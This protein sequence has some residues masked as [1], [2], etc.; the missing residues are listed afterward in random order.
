MKK[1]LVLFFLCCGFNF[2][3]SCTPPK[4]FLSDSRSL[5]SRVPSSADPFV[6][7][8]SPDDDPNVIF[9]FTYYPLYLFQSQGTGVPYSDVRISEFARFSVD[10]CVEKNDVLAGTRSIVYSASATPLPI[11]MCNDFVFSG[12]LEYL[13]S[14]VFDSCSFFENVG[15]DFYFSSFDYTFSNLCGSSTICES[16]G[17]YFNAKTKKCEQKVTQIL[18]I[19]GIHTNPTDAERNRKHLEQSYIDAVYRE[20]SRKN[21]AFIFDL[22]YNYHEGFFDD[23]GEV[24][25][26]KSMEYNQDTSSTYFETVATFLSYGT[27]NPLIGLYT[28]IFLLELEQEFQRV[29]SRNTLKFEQQNLVEMH[30]IVKQSLDDHYRV[31]LAPHSQG[32]LYATQIMSYYRENPSVAMVGLASVAGNLYGKSVYWTADDDAVVSGVR[33]FSNNVLPSNLD[34][35][36]GGFLAEYGKTNDKKIRDALNHNFIRSYVNDTLPSFKRIEN[37]ILSYIDTLKFPNEGE[38]K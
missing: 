16:D 7:S 6:F 5:Y 31:I 37:S 30:K 3:Y 4:L 38:Q 32:N 1:L 18:H 33:F 21:E 34:N 2:A 28:S 36:P 24:A 35:D 22:A 14:L 20:H 19:N 25:A 9:T 11:Y 8:C 27:L 29:L 12:S 26:Q 10:Y 23:L 13:S 15:S 17:K